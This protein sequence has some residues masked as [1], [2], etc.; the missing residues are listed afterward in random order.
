MLNLIRLRSADVESSSAYLSIIGN[1]IS[2][3]SKWRLFYVF[4]LLFFLVGCKYGKQFKTYQGR[5]F[6]MEYPPYLKKSVGVHPLAPFQA[7]N[8][9]REVYMFADDVKRTND[10]V[11]FCDSIQQDLVRNLIDPLTEKSN[12]NKDS[13]QF[14]LI[15][16]GT[17]NDKRLVFNVIATKGGANFYHAS[18]WLFRS[19]RELWE[20]DLIKSMLSLKESGISEVY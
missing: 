20:A 12:F 13:T 19:K 9:Y 16:T 7:K 18:G 6:S 8:E 3:V 1:I 5:T 11:S 15:A 14:H 17:I 2:L 10:F 4:V